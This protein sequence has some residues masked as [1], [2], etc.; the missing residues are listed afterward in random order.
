MTESKTGVPR[1]WSVRGCCR[2]PGKAPDSYSPGGR[3]R[4]GPEA[5]AVGGKW[6]QVL[7]C[8]RPSEGCEPCRTSPGPLLSCLHILC[9]GPALGKC[10]LHEDRGLILSQ[11]VR[12]WVR[13]RRGWHAGCLLITSHL[14][15]PAVVGEPSLQRP[16]L[17]S[18][19]VRPLGQFLISGC[20]PSLA[21]GPGDLEVDKTW[22][23]LPSLLRRAGNRRERE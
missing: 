11:G 7:V 5:Q 17:C 15:T 16:P 23:T 10:L 18:L 19:K 12:G 21:L 14:C 9:S 8:V 1:A 4:L 2:A 22:S 3:G 6:L 13:A 20:L